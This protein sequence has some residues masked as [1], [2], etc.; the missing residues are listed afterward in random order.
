MRQILLYAG[1][2]LALCSLAT[3][4]RSS[5]SQKTGPS[6]ASAQRAVAALNKQE[7]LACATM[8]DAASLALWAEDGVDL[9]PG[10][11]PMVGKEAISKWYDS[12]APLK[13][14][15]KMEYCTI[16]W[17]QIKIEGDW[18]WEWGIN[19]QKINFP[20]PQKPFVGEGKILLI[21]KKQASGEWKIELESWNSNPA[22]REVK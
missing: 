5:G 17:R 15:A 9:I 10:L 21:L 20:P 13:K 4:Q 18:A 8:D 22:A 16:D 6:S 19:R 12:L 3:A 2:G 7:A 11:Q 1:M 14:N